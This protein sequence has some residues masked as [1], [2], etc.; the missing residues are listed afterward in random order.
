[1]CVIA[2]LGFKLTDQCFAVCWVTLAHKMDSFVVP[3]QQLRHSASL[4]HSRKSID[5][6]IHGRFQVHGGYI[7]I[8]DV[9]NCAMQSTQV[10]RHA[11]PLMSQTIES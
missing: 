4:V 11:Q 2:Q 7:Y 8:P 3:E 5:K 1:M 10:L 9:R 6:A